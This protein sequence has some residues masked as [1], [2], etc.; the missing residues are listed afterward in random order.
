MTASVSIRRCDD[1]EP[2]RLV[3]TVAHCLEDISALTSLVKR[4]DRVLLKPNL[5]MSADPSRALVTHPA[6]VE[7]LASLLVDSG[8]RVHIGDG[9]PFGNLT[10]VLAKSGY[11]PFMKRLDIEPVQFLNKTAVEFPEGR[12]FH[13][14]ELAEEIFQFDAVINLPKLKTHCQMLLTL[15][16]KNLFGA[17]IGSDKAGWHLRAGRDDSTFATAL[18]QIYEKVRPAL[19][20]VDGILA[21]DGDGPTSGRPRQVGIVGASTDAIALDAVICK[22]VGFP[23][24]NLLTCVVGQAMGLGV[25]DERLIAVMGDYLEGF[26]L[27]DFRPPRSV[28]V[29]W[30]MASSNPMRRLARKH[31]V[32]RPEIDPST[33]LRCGVCRDHCPPRTI[34]LRDGFMQI[35]RSGC[36]S[37][38]CCHELCPHGAVKIVEPFIGRLLASITR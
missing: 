2:G 4:G 30:N 38:F 13:R 24:Q 8:A 23:V 35:E 5:V 14:I 33:C 3:M 21:M 12:L 36:I 20:I 37:C 31:L 19:S 10:R 9:P 7:A 25:C 28:S 27:A 15:A 11:D 18:V 16:V 17:V 1:Y 29:T 34:S 22:L 32:A 6:L 26:P